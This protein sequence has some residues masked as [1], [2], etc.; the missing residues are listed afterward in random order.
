[1]IFNGS[2]CIDSCGLT[3]V[4]IEKLLLLP[5]EFGPAWPPPRF[6]VVVAVFGVFVVIAFARA[7]VLAV[8]VCAR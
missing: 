5:P 8:S 6:A 4:I 3:R 2:E 7:R 1:M